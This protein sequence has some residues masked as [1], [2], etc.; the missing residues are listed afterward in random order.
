MMA[1]CTARLKSYFVC[2]ERGLHEYIVLLHSL[3]V[4]GIS[5]CLLLQQP[6]FLFAIGFLSSFKEKRTL[7][8]R[9]TSGLLNFT[10][11]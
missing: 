5:I 10:K 4:G 2:L 1:I 6:L 7:F 8:G 3:S 11:E 9:D